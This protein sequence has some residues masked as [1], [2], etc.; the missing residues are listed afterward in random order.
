MHSSVSSTLLVRHRRGRMQNSPMYNS[1]SHASTDSRAW[2]KLVSYYETFDR[3]D[4]AGPRFQSHRRDLYEHRVQ[5]IL[6]HHRRRQPSVTRGLAAFVPRFY[7]RSDVEIF[8]TP[9]TEAEAQI[10][11]ARTERFPNWKTLMEQAAEPRDWSIEADKE[12]IARHMA[13]MGAPTVEAF[14]AIR[15]RDL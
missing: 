13:Q 6:I 2:P 10:V 5:H 1:L 14:D 12:M 15:R 4:R 8:A 7:G 11:V 9:I 3:H